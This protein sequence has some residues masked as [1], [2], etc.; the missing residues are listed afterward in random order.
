MPFDEAPTD[1]VSN[2]SRKGTQ[3]SKRVGLF[4]KVLL[5]VHNADDEVS[6]IDI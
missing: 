1:L 5:V 3:S 4:G 2:Y 6:V